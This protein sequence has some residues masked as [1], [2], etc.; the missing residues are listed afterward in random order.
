[1][2]TIIIPSFNKANFIGDTI[3]SVQNQ[4]YEKWE[5]II[6][7]DGSTD[8]SIE[9]INSFCKEDSRIK[10]IERKE[11]PKGGSACRNIGLKAAKGNYIVFLDA[12]DLLVSN[13]LE[14]RL[15]KINMFPNN[16][17]WVF[18]IGTF[19]K[20]IGDHNSLW[21]P[22]GNQFLISFL[23]HDL[24]WHTMSVIWDKKYIN[25]LNGFDSAYPR[26]QDVELHTRALLNKEISFKTFAKNDI[27]AYY[28]ID[29]KRTVQNLEEQ[30]I[31]QKEGVF[32]YILKMYPL[33]KLQKEKRALNGT[34][35]SFLTRVNYICLVQNN[36]IHLHKKLSNEIID[37][38]SQQMKSKQWKSSFL[39]CYVFLYKKGFWKIKGF[40]FI[41]KII[42]TKV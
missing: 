32:L 10:L 39:N 13:C 4:T 42:F 17:F 1:M 11:L 3:N 38:N 19:Y 26:L 34:L 41:M 27:D 18:P 28:R 12:D 15:S 29:E 25:E 21:I 14:E 20:K 16:E 5:V 8:N 36:E 2:I 35:L 31:K 40:N 7:D 24:P 30:L 37:F 6:V 22:K 9:V 23:K 33:L